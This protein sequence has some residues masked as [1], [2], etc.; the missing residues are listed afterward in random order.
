MMCIHAHI[1][2]HPAIWI[3]AFI[4]FA[5]SANLDGN[6]GE[7][8]KSMVIITGVKSNQ[9][10]GPAQSYSQEKAKEIEKILGIDFV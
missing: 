9:L 1:S 7:G 2:V 8:V 3:G 6:M 5:F 10:Y 4:T